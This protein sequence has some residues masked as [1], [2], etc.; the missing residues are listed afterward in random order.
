MIKKTSLSD[1]IRRVRSLK[2]LRPNREVNKVF[3]ELVDYAL[4]SSDKVNIDKR[5]LEFIQKS[6]AQAEYELEKF[7]VQKIID[8]GAQIEDFIYYNNYLKLT[9]I[10]WNSLLSCKEH[11][12]H[13][14]LFVGSGPLPL[15]GL[16]LARDYGC[17]VTLMDISEEA[18]TLSKK[19]TLKLGLKNHIEVV[20]SDAL[21]FDKYIKFDVIYLAALAGISDGL[22]KR[23]LTKIRDDSK[24]N[25]HLVARSSFGN[26]EILYKPLKD[27]DIT[28]FKVD[29]EVKPYNDVVNSFLILRK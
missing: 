17:C 7:W 22:K 12:N 8:N 29:L 16:I 26:R 28:G 2:S 13:N 20:N 5:E 11:K 19:L 1:L 3:S 25:V 15:T 21:S 24:E 27:A 6:A 14:V 10:E 18:V 23:I 4:K 9:K